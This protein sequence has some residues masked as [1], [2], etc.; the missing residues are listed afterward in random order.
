MTGASFFLPVEI[1]ISDIC[2]QTGAVLTCAGDVDT[3]AANVLIDTAAPIA[4][5][6]PGSITFLDNPKFVSALA[7]TKA[8]AIICGEKYLDRVPA[9]V[10]ALIHPKPY[11]A[12]GKVLALMY[13][14]AMRP[15]PVTGETGISTQAYVD[16]TAS[17]EE[18]VIVEANAVIGAGVSIGRGCHILAGAVIGR[19][20]QIGR[21]ST[22]GANASVLC[23]LLGDNVI[24]H[25]GTQIGQD[26]FGFAMGPDGHKKIPQIGRV[27]IQDN[28]E[29]GAN[30]AIDRGA[31][32]DTIIGEGTKMDNLVHIAHNCVI[33]RHCLLIGMCG[34]AGS[35][36]LE[37]YVVVAAQAGI[38]GHLTIGMGAQIGG[39]SGV[40]NNIP[41]GE[42]VMGYPAVS[43]KIWMREAAQKR[44]AA[45]NNGKKAD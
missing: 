15:L 3:S 40:F 36:T 24:I 45:K 8:S 23:A 16:E 19:G 38:V 22:V 21:N 18:D 11:E 6:G 17:L 44:L 9:S 32:T 37:D 1:S 30:C 31:N 5:A 28:V 12:Y 39:G 7:E 42:K 20:V 25:N 34:M 29:I 26:G 4:I 10:A 43:A 2:A 35:V 33:G 41:A 13:P 27:I 14:T